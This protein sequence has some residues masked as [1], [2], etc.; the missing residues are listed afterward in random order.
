MPPGSGVDL[1]P[2]TDTLHSVTRTRSETSVVCEEALAPPGAAVERGWRA[3][4]LRGPIPFETTGVLASLTAPLS[5]AG[6][7][8]FTLSTYDTDLLLVKEAQAGLAE[9]VL[10][11]AGFLLDG[12]EDAGPP[13]GVS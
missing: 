7:S 13:T 10:R 6:V 3:L 1:P 5:R 9:A 2:R 4:S 11:E 8:V 12:G